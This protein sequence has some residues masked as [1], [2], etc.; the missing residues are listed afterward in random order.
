MSQAARAITTDE[1]ALLR[2]PGDWSRV[3]LAIYKPNV[4]YTAQLNGA[5][6]S[7]DMVGE[8]SFDNGTGTLSD[9]KA[10]MT[11][12]VG[13]TAG[14]RDLGTCRIRKAPISGTFYVSYT[15]EIA[16]ADE[17]HLTVMDHAVLSKKP[18]LVSAGNVLMD[19]EH[20]CSNQ[21]TVFD[22]VPIITTHAADYLSGGTL[23]VIFDASDSWV[24]GSTIS[25]YSWSAPGASA[26]SGMATSTPTIT[27]DTAGN[28]RVYCTVT[29]ANGKSVT[30]IRFVMVFD[31]N[32]KPHAA[33][34]QDPSIDYETG[35]WSFAARMFANA[36]PTE[37]IEGALCI[38]FA[39]DW[40]GSTKQ[41]IGQMASR[42]NIICWGYI[43]G[44][45]IEW[46]AEAGAVEFSVQGPHYWLKQIPA[47]PLVIDMATSTPASW[48]VMPALTVDRALWH[49]LHWRSNAT[50]L[51]NI[52]LTGNALY[53]PKLETM[54]GSLWDQLQDLAWKKLFGRI[55]INRLGTLYAVIDPQ[56][57][58]EASRTWETVMTLTKKDWKSPINIVRTKQRKVAMLSMSG[59]QV[60]T[61]AAVTTIYSLAMGHIHAQYG[62]SIILDKLLAENQTQFNSL[63]GLY[64][65]YKNNELEFDIT[66]ASNNRMIDL[67]PNQFLNITLAADDTPRGIE[68]SGNLIP[69]SITLRLDLE[70][71]V[72]T[73]DI[74]CEA[75]TFA[76]I[77]VNGDIPASTG[78]DD[79][80][81]SFPPFPDMGEMPPLN[82]V[83]LPPSA[84]PNN[85]PKRV[86]GVAYGFGVFWTD[87]FDEY[88]VNVKPAYS[89]MNSGLET[90]NWK[91]DIAQMVVTPSGAIYIMTDGSSAAGWSRVMRAASLGSAWQTVFLATQYS[92]N[93]RIT[94]L[95]VNPTVG[96]QVAIVVGDS[97]I[98]FGS[99]DTHKI[100]VGSGSSFSAGGYIRIK[101]AKYQ[102][103]VAYWKGKWIVGGHRPT[104]IGGSL[105][106]PKYWVYNAGGT[107]SGDADGYAWGAG[108]G[109]T[110]G[111]IFSHLAGSKLI[112]WGGNTTSGYSVVSDLVGTFTH[113]TSGIAPVGLQGLAVS[114]T[115]VNAMGNWGTTPYKS[116][117]SLASWSSV[118]ATI[119]T[120]S[121]VWDSCKDDYR[122]IFGGGT[123]VRLTMDQGATY[124]DKMGNLSYIAPLMDVILLRCIG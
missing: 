123:V 65:G 121:D 78:I 38:L 95:G 24:Y 51:I 63:A 90:S 12:W 101:Y 57:V 74:H 107:L 37:I 93:A 33:E 92:A 58:P 124:E 112:L 79:Y 85:H 2:T 97:Y 66:L 18:I 67:Y 29:A 3:H 45:S 54:E 36:D 42:E 83:Y 15:S 1:L 49:I 60:N 114:P 28:Y 14:A 118:A 31:P 40:Y 117:D 77:A 116:T 81:M 91:N 109:A 119:P 59:W 86:I 46:D 27:Y 55:G 56:L 98:N 16:W 96:D 64:M 43:A 52:N 69:R 10:E 20:S 7:T 94:G 5:L 106:T 32:N 48:E 4:I 39:E 111:D 25:G 9:V 120:G 113:V 34:V 115:G 100:Y 6:S 30:A 50:A 61:S 122:W 44:E 71:G 23:D 82:D 47:T 88:E 21:H 103:S 22:P 87:K 8:I 108:A 68:Y 105:A 62:E 84:Q 73:P 72:C 75:E 26:S 76:E 89:L 53:A 35:G 19:G 102:K 17:C 70:H 99:L 11:L 110:V 41:A 13:S 104:G 80:D